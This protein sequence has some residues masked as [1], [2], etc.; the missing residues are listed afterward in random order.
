MKRLLC[1]T[2]LLLT[3]IFCC[4]AGDDVTTKFP[5]SPYIKSASNPAKARL[6][7]VKLTYLYTYVTI[8]VVA[9][10]NM[11][12][13]KCWTSNETYITSGNDVL[14]PLLGLY[15]HESDTHCSFTRK[16]GFY[17]KDVKKGESRYYTLR[18]S[19]K[20][21]AG[22]TDF[23]LID[24][25]K[26]K[27]DRGF[28]F[29]N[30]TINNPKK[31]GFD[32]EKFCHE[33]INRNDD[34]I[35]GIYEEVGGNKYKVACI[36]DERDGT[37]MLM[38]LGRSGDAIPWWFVGDG[39]AVFTETAKPGVF[40]ANWV[41][42]NKT[43]NSDV[44]VAFDGSSMQYY[45]TAENEAVKGQFIKLYPTTSINGPIGTKQ[46]VAHT[47]TGFALCDNYIATNHH[48]I[49]GATSISIQGVNGDFSKK[50]N[51]R[52]VA[53][54][55]VNDLAILVVEGATIANKDIP[56]SVKIPTSD[57]GEDVFVVGYPMTQ[58]MGYEVKMTKGSINA[59][60][61]VLGD[62]SLYT[63]QAPVQGGNSGGPLFNSNG[64]VI[65]IICSRLNS[66]EAENVNYAIKT[67]CL[68]NLMECVI[69]TNILPKTNKIANLKQSEQFNAVKKYVYFIYC[70]SGRSSNSRGIEANDQNSAP[71]NDSSPAT[72]Q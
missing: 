66:E 69:P 30:R 36:K 16:D 18:F 19:G 37:Y 10:K 6:Y 38:Y 8:E 27:Q 13:L 2:L 40:K 70:T 49:E 60:S 25:A 53:S 50:Y 21:P 46:A 32:I 34:G 61:G 28:C 35:C 9:T 72:N 20:L 45:S 47:G 59:R 33:N 17:W 29:F 31:E 65:G 68:Q 24:N 56:Y 54:D 52:V 71:G 63:I 43:I 11:S 42:L 22:Y 3:S 39:K 51:A 4:F 41:M 62:T 64:D 55:P 7:E 15:K 67:S 14:L 57:V 44:I 23:S 26:S 5:N 48:V 12:K 58:M 1:T